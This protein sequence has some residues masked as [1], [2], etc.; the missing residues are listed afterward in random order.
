MARKPKEPPWI[1]LPLP[2]AQRLAGAAHAPSWPVMCCLLLLKFNAA[3]KGYPLPLSNVVL[4]EWHVSRR[5]KSRALAELQALGLILVKIE[6]R[7]CPL[8]TL[9]DL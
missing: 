5:Q 6:G 3:A 1:K 8:V 4:R 7:K 2:V 9:V